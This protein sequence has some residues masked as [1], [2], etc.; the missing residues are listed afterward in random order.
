MFFHQQLVQ[1]QEEHGLMPRKGYYNYTNPIEMV[2][3]VIVKKTNN[4][5]LIL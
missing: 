5:A 2:Y 4:D 1:M 3:L